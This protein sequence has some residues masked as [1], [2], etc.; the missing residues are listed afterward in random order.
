MVLLQGGVHLF[1]GGVLPP[2][3]WLDKPLN[4]TRLKIL[5]SRKNQEKKRFMIRQV[6]ASISDSASCQITLVV[7]VVVVV[8]VF[9]VVARCMLHV[10]C[11]R[12]SDG[13]DLLT[14][15]ADCHVIN[16]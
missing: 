4:S 1:Q 10:C 7:V 6:A 11:Y 3:G 12:I 2:T 14:T 16:K 5:T 13:H 15:S 9:V 8:V